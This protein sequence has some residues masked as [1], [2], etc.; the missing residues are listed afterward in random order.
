MESKKEETSQTQGIRPEDD[1]ANAQ[2]EFDFSG[3]SFPNDSII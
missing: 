1:L 3:I 2:F